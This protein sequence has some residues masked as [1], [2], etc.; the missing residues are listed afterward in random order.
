MGGLPQ[1]SIASMCE[2]D[3]V[4]GILWKRIGTELPPDFFLRGQ[5]AVR[6]RNGV[7]DQ[8]CLGG[9]PSQR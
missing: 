7:R 2:F 3:I 4:I 8:V 6:E 9:E 5:H 1:E